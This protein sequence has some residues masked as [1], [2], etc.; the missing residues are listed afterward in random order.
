MYTISDAQP[1]IQILNG[2]PRPVIPGGA[3]GAMTPPIFGTSVNPISTRGA[4]YAH[5]S[6]LAPPD[7]RTFRRPCY[8]VKQIWELKAEN[9]HLP[10]KLSKVEKFLLN[11]NPLSILI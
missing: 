3:G 9:T 8:Q 10:K 1:E 11:R 5:T 2:L 6:L 7:F 4:D